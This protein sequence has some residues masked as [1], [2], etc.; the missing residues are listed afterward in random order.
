MLETNKQINKS[1]NKAKKT[2]KSTQL[3]T[4]QMEI[5]INEPEKNQ[6]I[7]RKKRKTFRFK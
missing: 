6:I 2:K 7:K 3:I 4:I 1:K 5:R